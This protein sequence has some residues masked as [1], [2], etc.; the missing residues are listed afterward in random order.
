MDKERIPY[1]E[2]E[3]EGGVRIR[4]GY[5]QVRQEGNDVRV[6]VAG[7]LFDRNAYNL[8]WSFKA[9]KLEERRIRRRLSH[10]R[11]VIQRYEDVIRNSLMF[12][13]IHISVNWL[14]PSEHGYSRYMLTVHCPRLST[15]MPVLTVKFNRYHLRP[16]STVFNS[17]AMKMKDHII[18]DDFAVV[19]FGDVTNINSLDELR[20]MLNDQEWIDELRRSR[21]VTSLSARQVCFL[22]EDVTRL[23]PCLIAMQVYDVRQFRSRRTITLPAMPP[24]ECKSIYDSLFGPDTSVIML[25]KTGSIE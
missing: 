5:T 2:V 18:E 4:S 19:T 22:E 16:M 11:S 21:D 12:R 8:Y 14:A 23:A 25:G 15:G 3:D 1:I 17:K 10:G 6:E 9:A 20:R 24:G 13:G 7:K